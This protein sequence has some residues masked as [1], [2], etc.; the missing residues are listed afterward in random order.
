MPM[1]EGASLDIE[2]IINSIW[3]DDNPSDHRAIIFNL[4]IRIQNLKEILK[5][6][7]TK[8]RQILIGQEKEM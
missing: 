7:K 3:S 4:E 1:P 5:K 6:E 8:L 2:N